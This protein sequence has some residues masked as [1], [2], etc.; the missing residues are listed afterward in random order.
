MEELLPFMYQLVTSGTYNVTNAEGENE[1]HKVNL[2]NSA[3]RYYI[4]DNVVHR[5]EMINVDLRILTYQVKTM[6][7]TDLWR[8]LDPQ[9]WIQLRSGKVLAS[10]LIHDWNAL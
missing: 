7:W 1:K 4:A 5:L 10:S 3:E 8:G 6:T 2:L 9:S